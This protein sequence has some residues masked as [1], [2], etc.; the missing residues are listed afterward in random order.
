MQLFKTAGRSRTP[1]AEA[2]RR[3]SR[4]PLRSR[5]TVDWP[6]DGGAPPVMEEVAEAGRLWLSVR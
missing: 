6:A 1:E 2:G 3:R 5:P 4:T